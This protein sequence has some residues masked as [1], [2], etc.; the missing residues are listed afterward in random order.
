MLGVVEGG[1]LSSFWSDYLKNK[2]LD[3]MRGIASW[4]TPGTSYFAMMTEAPTPLGGGTEVNTA[5][6]PR[7]PFLNSSVNWNA[8]SAGLT[9]NKTEM[10]FASNALA[11]LGTIVGIA[12]YDAATAGNL[13]AYGDLSVPKT[14]LTGMKFSVLAG[15]G[16][17]TY[18]D[19]V[20]LEEE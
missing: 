4:S 17:F 10:L 5:F 18:I 8:A 6:Q 11:D 14:I 16:Q 12:E 19:D 7:L 13:L 20:P 9:S 2:V 15:N 3:H 1:I